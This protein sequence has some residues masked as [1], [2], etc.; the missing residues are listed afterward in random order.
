MGKDDRFKKTKRVILHVDLDAFFASV[1]MKRHPELKGR[2]V[3]V[4]GTGDPTKR[5]VVSAASYEAR[6]FGIKS[7]MPLR[8]AL[9]KCPDAV[10]LPVD[11][12]TYEEVSERF[13]EILRRYSSLVESFGLDEA[14]LELEP[15]AGEDVTA[16][17]VERAK[18]IKRTI[19]RELGITASVGIAPNKLLAKLAGG[20][21]KPNG[22][23]VIREE[24]VKDILENLPVR[25]LWGVGE[26]TEKRLREMGV[27]TVGEL[28]R[29]PRLYL[30]RNFGPVFGRMLY[31]H[32]RGIDDSPVIPFFEPHSM[33][34][35]VTFE[36]DTGDM[37]I[38]RETLY[39]LA[40][41][42]VKRLRREGFKGKKVTI[43]IRYGDF[44]T[45]TRSKTLGEVTSSFN[46]VWIAVSRLL[47]E[48]DL[49]RKVRL[50]GVK[51]SDLEKRKH[52]EMR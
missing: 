46:D 26:K 35:E 51:I 13:K 18:E 44:H 6:K 12:K 23:F 43:K 29:L 14:F 48:V 20:M 36:A 27:K 45:I 40:E 3:V 11:F 19:R 28:A 49:S 16:R 30:E 21:K 39:A 25:R 15:S 1:E 4:G 34:R 24:N 8:T 38:I 10:F 41:D 50:V 17:A 31:E 9:R 5:G 32:S 2:P 22:L 52:R 7:G 37:Y 47:D 42:V 33:S